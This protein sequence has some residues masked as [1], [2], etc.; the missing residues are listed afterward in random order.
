MS[1]TDDEPF[2]VRIRANPADAGARLAYAEWLDARHNP[3]G[4]ALRAEVEARKVLPPG[5]VHGV[6][7]AREHLGATFTPEELEHLSVLPFL[8]STLPACAGTH[9][10][11]A[12]APLSV[13]EIRDRHPDLFW[14]NRGPPWYRT[15]LFAWDAELSAG[16]RLRRKGPHPD[17]RGRT[18]EEQRQLL[19]P[20]E[21]VPRACQ[22][23]YAAAL[24]R[25]TASEPLFGGWVRC[26][27]GAGDPDPLAISDA[28]GLAILRSSG[29]LRFPR[30]G[31]ATMRIA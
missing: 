27:G 6:L 14:L 15:E 2:L 3:L 29:H 24:H 26:R 19:G 31:L 30:I 8:E 18:Y 11:A 22:A 9:V 20:L 5:D 17:S 1:T 13:R 21:M 10:L 12:I 23:V 25:L 28:D 16:W 7:E 4:G